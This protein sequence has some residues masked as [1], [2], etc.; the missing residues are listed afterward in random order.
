MFCQST[1]LDSPTALSAHVPRRSL[2]PQPRMPAD[3]W[4]GQS[5]LAQ[6]GPGHQKNQTIGCPGCV[7]LPIKIPH[8]RSGAW[9]EDAQLTRDIGPTVLSHAWRADQVVWLGI[10]VIGIV[11][12]NVA[13]RAM[14]CGFMVWGDGRREIKKIAKSSS[15]LSAVCITADDS[16]GVPCIHFG[17][18]HHW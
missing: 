7:I 11:R 8:R 2:R 6:A 16:F 17:Q 9:T 13:E 10:Q 18:P 5:S 14:G 3:L 1:F 15:G 12:R 4:P